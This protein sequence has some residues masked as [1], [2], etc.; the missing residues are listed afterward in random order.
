MA[1][2]AG[3]QCTEAEGV[4]RMGIHIL[5]ST[6]LSTAGCDFVRHQRKAA[7]CVQRSIFRIRC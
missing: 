4:H 6:S 7:G 5:A 1:A 3:E 2:V